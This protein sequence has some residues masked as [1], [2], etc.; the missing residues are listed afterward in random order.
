MLI[1]LTSF[2][3]CFWFL[4]IGSCNLQDLTS[5]YSLFNAIKLT[6]NI[7][8]DEIEFLSRQH[9]KLDT[10][11]LPESYTKRKQKQFLAYQYILELIIIIYISIQLLSI[12][13]TE[14]YPSI[15]ITTYRYN[16][17]CTHKHIKVLKLLTHTKKN[18][19][20]VIL[21]MWGKEQYSEIP[22]FTSSV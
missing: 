20:A 2:N 3:R 8:D 11:R 21:T 12:V 18:T 6:H 9:N 14:F 17:L 16:H 4:I 7:K 22:I 19:K 13:L 5:V 15:H 1:H 10:T